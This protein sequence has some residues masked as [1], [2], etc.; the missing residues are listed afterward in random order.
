MYF[1]DYYENVCCLLAIIKIMKYK[2]YYAEEKRTLQEY[3]NNNRCDPKNIVRGWL[4]VIYPS[5]GC[6]WSSERR[7]ILHLV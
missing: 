5:P 3:N 6:F 1:L 2:S 4:A 7:V